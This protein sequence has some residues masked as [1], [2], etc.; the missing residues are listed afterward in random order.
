MHFMIGCVLLLVITSAKCSKRDKLQN[1]INILEQK[2]FHD[3]KEF[4]E[5]ISALISMANQSSPVSAD[6]G[7][8]KCEIDH[9]KTVPPSRYHLISSNCKDN[10]TQQSMNLMKKALSEEKQH[11]RKLISEVKTAAMNNLNKIV[12]VYEDIKK[13]LNEVRFMQETCD[14]RFNKILESQNLIQD[15]IRSIHNT[16]DTVTKDT[17]ISKK[18]EK[19]VG[20]LETASN[21]LWHIHESSLYFVGKEAKNWSEAVDVCK[22]LGAYLAQVDDSSENEFLTNLAKTTYEGSGYGVWLGG[23][24]LSK[25]GIWIWEHSETQ[26]AFD[27]WATEEPNGNRIEN[28]LHMY[29]H[30]NWKWNDLRCKRELGY[31]CEKKLILV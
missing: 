13:E 16:L 14:N 18:L 29:R 4:R 24:D 25:E 11:T 2:L 27:N 23:S 1:R 12:E 8:C 6:H 28:C 19:R 31:I 10:Y 22:T 20:I 5:D 7:K 15:D 3:S 21:T 17:N 26:I 30:V 9:S